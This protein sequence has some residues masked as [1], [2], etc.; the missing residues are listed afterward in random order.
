MD[1]IIN[2]LSDNSAL[3]VSICA[4]FFTAYQAWLSRQHNKLSVKPSLTTWSETIFDKNRNCYIYESTLINAGLG[5][6][7]IKSYEVLIDGTPIPSSTF[8]DIHRAIEKAFPNYKFIPGDCYY[9]LLRKT[10]VIATNERTIIGTLVMTSATGLNPEDGKRLN[11]R[12][13]YESAYGQEQVYD[14]RNHFDT[15]LYK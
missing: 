2:F 10:H 12:I 1:C 7:Y 13:V 5:P 15:S 6:A 9:S 4:L 3:I 11:V 14:S 8:E